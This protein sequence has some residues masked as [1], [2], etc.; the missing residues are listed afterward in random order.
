M[1]I[2]VYGNVWLWEREA[3]KYYDKSV[4]QSQDINQLVWK[5]YTIFHKTIIIGILPSHVSM[6]Y[7]DNF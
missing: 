4:L 7:A 6:T 5:K 2:L 3:K 1:D